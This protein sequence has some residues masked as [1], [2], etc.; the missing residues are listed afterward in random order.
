MAAGGGGGS[1][2]W[3]ILWFLI[4][5]FIAFPIA[6]FCAGFYILIVPFTVCIEALAVRDFLMNGHWERVL[7]HLSS[8]D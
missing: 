2:L 8:E 6:F 1:P 7:L 5:I 3:M 4:L